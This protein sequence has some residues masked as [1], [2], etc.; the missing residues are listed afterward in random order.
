MSILAEAQELVT[1]RGECWSDA[2]LYR[3][4]GAL[5]LRQS[6]DN[7]AEAEECFHN[8]IV[9]ARQQQAKSWEFRAA[10]SLAHLWQSQ[11]KQ[12]EPAISLSRFTTGLP[13]GL[14]RRT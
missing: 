2:E 14:T 3:L 1:Q 13:K 5:L 10:T 11:G 9:I 8:A 6:P 4:K 12:A 7:Q